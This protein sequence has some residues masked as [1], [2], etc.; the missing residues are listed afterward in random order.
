[1]VIYPGP[2]SLFSIPTFILHQRSFCENFMEITQDKQKLQHMNNISP[3]R[4]LQM[5]TDMTMMTDLYHNTMIKFLKLHENIITVLQQVDF[6]PKWIFSPDMTFLHTHRQVSEVKAKS[7]SKVL[8]CLYF[9]TV[10]ISVFSYFSMTCR[11]SPLKF[12]GLTNR[13]Q[14]Y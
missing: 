13:V 10:F 7:G 4:R 6:V 9:F 3:H 11:R 14:R 5:V 12:S 1:M 2:E 8:G